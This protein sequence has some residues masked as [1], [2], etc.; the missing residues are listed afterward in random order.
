MYLFQHNSNECI[1]YAEIHKVMNERRHSEFVFICRYF[2]FLNI[3]ISYG[4]HRMNEW[5]EVYW[6]IIV[7]WLSLQQYAPAECMNEEQ[8][9]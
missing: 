4:T 5:E 3:I 7:E 2:F 1:L 8:N 9:K 6:K